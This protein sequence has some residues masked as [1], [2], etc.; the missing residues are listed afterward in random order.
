M[1]ENKKIEEKA[2][3]TEKTKVAKN[4]NPG[5][6]GKL[7]KLF[8]GSARELKHVTWSSKRSTTMNSIMVVIVLLLVGGVLGALDMLFNWV[9]V[10]IMNLY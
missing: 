6:F 4:K 7:A 8:V 10:A 3:S 2:T 1:S 9:L 5:V